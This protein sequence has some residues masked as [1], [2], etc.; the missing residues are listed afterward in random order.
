MGADPISAIANAAGSLFN[1][2]GTIFQAGAIKKQAYAERV[3]AEADKY[4]SGQQTEQEYLHNI[5]DQENNLSG[6]VSQMYA[7]DNKPVNTPM[8]IIA[9]IFLVIIV[10]ALKKS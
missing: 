6:I 3:R 10:M 1:S 9:G 7:S 2:V 5:N 4:I 8:I